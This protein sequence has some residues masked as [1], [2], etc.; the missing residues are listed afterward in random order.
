MGVTNKSKGKSAK[1]SKK[2]PPKKPRKPHQGKKNLIALADRSTE[3][4]RKIA[5]LGGIASGKV[6]NQRKSF[7]EIAEAILSQKTPL[8]GMSEASRNAVIQMAKFAGV[9]KPEDITNDVLI[10][11]AQ[12][13]KAMKGNSWAYMAIRDSVG[14][15]PKYLD[16]GSMKGAVTVNVG[17]E[18]SPAQ[19]LHNDIMTFCSK[20][21]I[22]CPLFVE[23]KHV[24]MEGGRGGGK[25]ELAARVVLLYSLTAKQTKILCG[26]EIQNS[27]KESVKSMLDRLI[28]FYKLRDQFHSTDKSITCKTT[29]TS[30]IFLGLKAATMDNSDALKSL[31]GVSLVWVE[32][33]QS[34]SM[35]TIEKLIPTIRI[36]NVEMADKSTKGSQLIYT[37]NRSLESDPI[38]NVMVESKREDVLHININYWMNPYLP[39][40]L[41]D[42]ADL[43]KASNY[44]RWLHIW[45]GQPQTF[46]EDSLWPTE[47]ITKMKRN[48]PFDRD[49]Y[50]RVVVSTDPAQTDNEFSNEYGITVEG[51]TK[52]GEGH[53]IADLSG[54]Y[55]PNEWAKK[56]ID[57][58]F[59]Y[60]ADCVVGEVNA[61]G[62]FIKSTILSIDPKV[63]VKE[64]RAHRDK[65]M[66]AVP[67]AN[68][69]QMGK[70]AIIC[71][72]FPKLENQMKRMTTKGFKGAPGE[73]PDRVEA[74][75]WGFY[76]LFGLSEMDTTELVFKSS[77]L[78]PPPKDYDV[79]YENTAYLG[80][81]G[82]QYGLFICDI[83][84]EKIDKDIK[85]Y[86]LI[87]DYEKGGKE[88]VVEKL[89]ELLKAGKI[90]EL[91]IPDDITGGPI[92]GELSKK[93]VGIQPISIENYLNKK[94]IER[95]TQIVSFVQSGQVCV[96]SL[97]HKKYNNQQGDLFTQEIC[98]YNPEQKVERPLLAAVCN[99]LFLENDIA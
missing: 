19:I 76:E 15:N 57:A 49:N 77:M 9:A 61:G 34:L 80:F 4:Q 98:Q 75:E 38:H 22:V 51:L 99:A 33:A 79:E 60:G 59:T 27:I 40:T 23:K 91:N 81:D 63:N 68:L 36:D 37:Y 1:K 70:L 47:L 46:F 72:G 50:V 21:G 44:S 65:I 86:F 52:G 42:E 25:S 3:E 16:E 13:T 2:K 11:A 6:R 54:K 14:E 41:K 53:V 48:D 96:E 43:M 66:R 39:Q 97:P 10:M 28:D 71:G 12:F 69:S 64:V 85:R 17:Q 89:S 73:S 35:K 78:K 55:S 7:R 31:D 88:K 94:M 74:M 67:I 32:E 95:V 18:I 84:I 20:A 82:N 62:D 45:S 90:K 87:K 93:F 58:Y 56:C 26:R 24:P 92:I 83:I 5:Q 30:I 29:G 8:D